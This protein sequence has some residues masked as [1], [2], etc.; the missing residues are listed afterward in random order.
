MHPEPEFLRNLAL[1]LCVAAVTT[2]VFQ[3][4]HQPVVLGYLLAGMLVSPHTPF[5]LFADQESTQTLSEIGVILLMFSLGLEFSLRRLLRAG[6]G[7]VLV[8]VVQCSIMLWLG[9]VTAQMFGWT[10]LESV[11]AGAVIAISSTTIIVKAF[12]E[13]RIRGRLTDV[14]FGVLIVE[15]IIAIFLIA[16]LTALSTGADLSAAS[17]GATAARLAG[18]LAA[19]LIVG[20]LVVPRAIRM[21]VRLGRPE[22]TVVASVG[23]CFAFALIAAAA[24]YSVALGAFLAGALVGESGVEHEVEQ[25]VQPV[26]DVFAALFFVAVGMLIDPALI[27]RHWIAVLS[28]TAVVVVGKVVA[29]AFAVFLTGQGIRLSVQ[30]GMSLAQIGEFSFI[31]AS[32]GLALGAVGDFLYPVAVAV[33]AMT[34]LLTPWL[35]RG[36]D[37]VATWLDRKLPRP[38]QTFASLYG[39]WLE[40]LRRT[41]DRI[42]TAAQARRIGGFLF[43]DAALLGAVVIGVSIGGR[44]F[45]G[46]VEEVVGLSAPLAWL[47]V[48]GAATALA[49]PFWLGII[50]NARALA[51]LLGG[52]TMP[53]PSSGAVDLADAPRRAF[54]VTLQL[55]VLLLI[56]APLVAVTQPFLPPFQGAA[57]LVLVLAALSVAF[58]RNAMN[59]EAHARAGAQAVLE[60]I[61]NQAQNPD[62]GESELRRLHEALPGLGD[63]VP[64]RLSPGSHAVGKTLAA[65]NLRGLTAATVLAILRGDERVLVPT[66]KEVLQQGDV[67]AVAGSH[68]AIDA[69]RWLLRDGPERGDGEP[70]TSADPAPPRE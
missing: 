55:A 37:P 50:R 23:L 7:A 15:D 12:E 36:S 65:L 57:V 64:L 32:V 67:L 52:A 68:E 56:G 27:A 51:V 48:L 69:A 41:P 30:A 14:V 44:R 47:L 9:Y 19:M 31:I 33:S 34:T 66:G 70:T 38:I 59:L 26:R 1:V 54:I 4:L 3:R 17:L 16:V 61:A 60:V 10:A 25:R 2:V 45:I 13:Q 46:P 24:G 35:I 28:L 39:A 62:A 11:Y 58:W 53:A 43:I 21:V 5:P 29:V 20:M 63:P 40:D 18:F 42:G 8:G 22:T 6:A 49:A